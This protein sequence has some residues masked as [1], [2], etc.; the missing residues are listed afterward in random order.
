MSSERSPAAAGEALRD[1]GA[2]ARGAAPGELVAA[3]CAGPGG[4]AEEVVGGRMA[5]GA[6]LVVCAPIGGKG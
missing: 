6:G 3:G 5:E 4:A 1:P 2:A